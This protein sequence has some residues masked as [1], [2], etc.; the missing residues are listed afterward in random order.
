M[1]DKSASNIAKMVYIAIAKIEKLSFETSEPTSKQQ[2]ELEQNYKN[3]LRRLEGGMQR[4]LE[5]IWN[6]DN[7]KKEQL[8]LPYKGLDL[9]SEESA[10]LF[11]LSQQEMIVMGATSGAAAGAAIDL[12]T[13]GHTL[14]LGGAIGAVV[15]GVSAYFGFDKLS[16][17][18]IFGRRIGQRYLQMGPMKNRNFP[19]IL[20]GRSLY[21][22]V[23]LAHHSHAKRE[24]IKFSMDSSFKEAWLTDKL[25]KELEKFHKKFRSGKEIDNEELLEYEE[26][27]KEIL[28]KLIES[29]R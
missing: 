15:G 28:Y 9:F 25:K 26:L 24:V 17:I 1:I 22:T 27:I 5:L 16:D 29:N 23:V 2:E 11:G 7:F 12:F 21:Y 3:T 13:V 14:L 20:L 18:K 10:S 8:L 6:H 4:N 19:Y